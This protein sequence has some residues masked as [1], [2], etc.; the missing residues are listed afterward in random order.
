MGHFISIPS[1]APPRPVLHIKLPILAVKQFT[2]IEF[3]IDDIHNPLSICRK[4][5]SGSDF[6]RVPIFIINVSF[7][8]PSMHKFVI[9]KLV[10]SEFYDAVKFPVK[11]TKNLIIGHC[12]YWIAYP[13]APDLLTSVLELGY[14]IVDML[15]SSRV[16]IIHFS[17][18]VVAVDRP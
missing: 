3:P 6:L 7:V 17:R 1:V 8:Q 12:G 5:F 9:T 10:E 14:E 4:F 11:P 15:Q 16:N 18:D 13:V 2:L